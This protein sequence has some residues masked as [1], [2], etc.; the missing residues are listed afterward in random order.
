MTR[1]STRAVARYT[2]TE[3]GETDWVMRDGEL[4]GSRVAPTPHGTPRIG[5]MTYQRPLAPG[6]TVR[7]EFYHEPGETDNGVAVGPLAFLLQPDGVRLRW[8]AAPVGTKREPPER[9]LEGGA[10]RLP[11]KAREWNEV[12]VTLS[13]ER[14][15]VLT[16]NG[17][18]VGRQALGP[19]ADTSFGVVYL[20]DRTA[21]RVRNV[22]LT[23]PWPTDATPL[24]ANLLAR[25]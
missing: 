24:F 6:D 11:L 21:A 23:G 17:V 9:R 15:A 25:P 18:Q 1:R 12:K 2:S 8:L 10:A 19:D 16:L 20:S 7:Y 22:T 13:A 4:R 3:R 14:E 5:R